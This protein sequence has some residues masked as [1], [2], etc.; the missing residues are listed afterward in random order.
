MMGPFGIGKRSCPGQAIAEL[1]ILIYTVNLLRLVFYSPEFSS[2]LFRRCHIKMDPNNPLLNP[3][4]EEEWYTLFSKIPTYAPQGGF[5]LV[6][7]T[8][9]TVT[10]REK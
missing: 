6:E 3:K 7:N 5:M 8:R 10:K 4:T 9:I 1:Q 2:S